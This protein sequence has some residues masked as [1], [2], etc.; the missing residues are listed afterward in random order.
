M[1]KLITIIL[2]IFINGCNNNNKSTTHANNDKFIVTKGIKT[3]LNIL[4][5]DYTNGYNINELSIIIKQKPKIGTITLNDTTKNIL[6]ICETHSLSNNDYFSY[7]IKNPNGTLSN[8]AKVWIDLT[9]IQKQPKNWYIKIIAIDKDRNIKTSDTKFGELDTNNTKDYN[10]KIFKPFNKSDLSILINNNNEEFKTLFYPYST[11]DKS[12]Y[13]TLKSSSPT[14]N[15]VL[16]WQGIYVLHKYIDNYNRTRYKEYRYTKNPIVYHL[17]LVDMKN[18]MEIPAIQNDRIYEYRFN[19]NG[20]NSRKFQWILTEEK[21]DLKTIETKYFK[22]SYIH[23]DIQN[24][25]FDIH[26]PPTIDRIDR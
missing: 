8:E 15:I 17:K 20:E 10:L 22:T 9:N 14:S 11:T 7:V 26:T 12:W 6:Y 24:I 16:K 25:N 23:N 19:M 1:K 5:N 21:I 18:N 4:E 3:K 13:F 2:F